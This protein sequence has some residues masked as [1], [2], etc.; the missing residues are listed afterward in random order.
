M[1]QMSTALVC[2]IEV[3]TIIL[4]EISSLYKNKMYKLE[5]IKY[6]LFQFHSGRATPRTKL[7]AGFQK[8]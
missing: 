4:M 7:G 3:L 2:F 8:R 1:N 6:F 5:T